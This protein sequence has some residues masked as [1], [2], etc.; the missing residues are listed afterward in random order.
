MENLV[1]NGPMVQVY[2]VIYGT[3]GPTNIVCVLVAED[4][5]QAMQNAFIRIE[6]VE[7][8]QSLIKVLHIGSIYDLLT[9]RRP[10]AVVEVPAR[11]I[12]GQKSPALPGT[13]E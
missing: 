4:D 9:A 13:T 11:S 10:L 2:S 3:G 6:Y 1:Y 12:T 7:G 5:T 8:A